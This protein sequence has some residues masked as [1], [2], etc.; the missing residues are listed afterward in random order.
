ML[1]KFFKL[2]THSTIVSREVVAK[3]LMFENL[4][5]INLIMTM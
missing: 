1:K 2:S 4:P 3:L 5:N